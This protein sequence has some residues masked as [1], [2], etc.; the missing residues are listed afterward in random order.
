MSE[1]KIPARS[2]L[3]PQ[4]TWAT[5]DLYPSDEAWEADIPKVQAAIDGLR[6]CQGTLGQSA[7]GLLKFLQLEDELPAWASPLPATPCTCG[8]RTP[9]IPKPRR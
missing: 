4:Y 8:T 6:A 9:G 1:Q 2:E 7:Q 3:D 5:T